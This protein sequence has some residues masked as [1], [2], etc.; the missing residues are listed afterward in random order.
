[1]NL[2]IRYFLCWH[3][4][5]YML[6][7]KSFIKIDEASKLTGLS[8]STIYKLT[9]LGK[10]PCYKRGRLLFKPDEI[11]AWIEEGR[12]ETQSKLNPY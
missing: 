7:E 2:T 8:R 10:F 5:N 4:I 11:Q 12:V 3:K 6:T 1:M 9:A